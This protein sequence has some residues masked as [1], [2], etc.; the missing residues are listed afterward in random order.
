MQL[1][2]NL[3]LKLDETVSLDALDQSLTYFSH[4]YQV[5]LQSEEADCTRLMSDN[6]RV[7]LAACDG[8]QMDLARLR[9]VAQVQ[10]YVRLSDV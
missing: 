5:H 7:I 10:C 3:F 1:L 2:T 8:L 6:S 4:L 9:L